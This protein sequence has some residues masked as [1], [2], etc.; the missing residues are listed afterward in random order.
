MT[1]MQPTTATDAGRSKVD[2]EAALLKHGPWL[3]T[4]IRH[5]LGEAAPVEDVLQ[6]VGLAATKSNNLPTDPERMAP[7]LYRVA[8]RQCL[9]YRRTRGRRRRFENELIQTGPVNQEPD[10]TPLDWLLE[11]ERLNSVRDALAQLPELDREILILKYTEN[12][13][14]RDLAKRLGVTEHVIEHRLL[15]VRQRMRRMLTSAGVEAT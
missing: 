2:W 15:K 5:R 8:V 13:T 4:V 11:S 10:S 12:W 1:D 7:W 14:Y 3:R 9:F 6:E